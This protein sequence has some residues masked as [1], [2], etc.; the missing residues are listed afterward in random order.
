MKIGSKLHFADRKSWRAWLT[1]HHKT[2]KE[3]WLVFFRKAT[4]KPCISYN[5]AVEEALCFGWIDS[6]VKSI[7]NESYVQRFSVRRS[8]SNLSQMNRER[9][10]LLLAQKKMRKAGLEAI[11]HVFSPSENKSEKFVIPDEIQKS[12]K[13]NILAWTNFQKLPESYKRIRIAYIESRKRHGEEFY[14][15]ALRHFISMTAKNKQY[16]F[17]K[18]MIQR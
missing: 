13:A 18:E 4:G 6:I 11:V 8:K 5:D 7:D 3:I 9:V 15:K 16:G 12:L 2:E 14:Q 1:K 10:E 17:V